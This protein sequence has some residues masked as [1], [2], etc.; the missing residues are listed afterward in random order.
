MNRKEEA[1]LREYV[2]SELSRSRR[3]DEGLFGDAVKKAFDTVVP[4]L[5]EIMSQLK[6]HT[7]ASKMLSK[8][9]EDAGAG[10]AV[11]KVTQIGKAFEQGSKQID[12]AI[13]APKK[14]SKAYRMYERYQRDQLVLA[15]NQRVKRLDE[16]AFL[17]PVL[18]AAFNAAGLVFGIIGG[19]PLLLKLAAYILKWT[20]FK[21]QSEAIMNGP[22]KTMHHIEEKFVD[23]MLPDKAVY[24][25]YKKLNEKETPMSLEDFKK[26]EIK[27]K[28]EKRIW[29]IIL[30]PWLFQGITHLHHTF[31]SLYNVAHAGATAVKAV[32]TGS[33]A[34]EIGSAV[35]SSVDFAK[36]ASEITKDA[37]AVASALGKIG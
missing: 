37:A 18:V 2:R 26:S 21:K 30:I 19:I 22:F 31:H 20:G 5:E 34:A 14:E 16:V 24:A 7:D 3:L 12:S 27:K 15:S 9:L 35:A 1:I 33:A 4:K 36:A 23:F 29:A 32:E 13:P 17:V 6:S 8:F 28:Y 25:L 10:D 11:S